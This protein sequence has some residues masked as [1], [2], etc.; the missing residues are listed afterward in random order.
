MGISGEKRG[1][2]K[3]GGMFAAVLAAAMFALAAA[4]FASAAATTV[5]EDLLRCYAGRQFNDVMGDVEKAARKRGRAFWGEHFDVRNRLRYSARNGDIGGDADAIVPLASRMT[6]QQDAEEFQ[7]AL[8]LQAGV[9]KWLYKKATKRHDARYGLIYRF[10]D[11]RRGDMFGLWGFARHDSAGGHAGMSLGGDYE[12]EHGKASAA[13]FM[14]FSGWQ[15]GRAGY[16][17][18]AVQGGDLSFQLRFGR[19]SA[20]ARVSRWEN[21]YSYGKKY[22]LS[23][24]AE[25][26]YNWR[27]WLSFAGSWR[28]TERTSGAIRFLAEVRIPLG[29]KKSA[30]KYRG[31]FLRKAHAPVRSVRKIK[32][33]ERKI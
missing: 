4:D 17:Q 21:L 9:S 2:A 3:S 25:L 19:L 31:D 14:P 8:F 20:K 26:R 10:A 30:R 23:A 13:Y 7:S 11:G 24:K 15:S 27:E 33:R 18:R 16:E 1:F 29:A 6:K 22:R 12:G 5:C 28:G 32:V